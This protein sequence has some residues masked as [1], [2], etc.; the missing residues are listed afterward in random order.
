LIDDVFD[1]PTDTSCLLTAEF[2]TVALLLFAAALIAP[3]KLAAPLG[4]DGTVWVTDPSGMA[5]S[6][7]A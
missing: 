3:L 1:F 6:G 5:K 4:L 7:V 2:A